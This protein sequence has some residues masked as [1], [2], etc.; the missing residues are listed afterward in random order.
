MWHQRG[1]SEKPIVSLLPDEKKVFSGF[2]DLVLSYDELKDI[3]SNPTAYEAWHAALSS[4]YAIYLIVDRETGKQYVGSAYGSGGLLGRWSC[5]VGT[6]HGNNKLMH[7][8]IC[9]YPERYN[10]FQFSILQIL[11]KTLTADEVVAI[12]SRYKR[13][14]LSIEFG[15]NGN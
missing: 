10:S 14:L 5:Y 1:S 7:E 6:H 13:K 2:E 12:E 15:M 3:L 4:V 9:K 11:P 8:L